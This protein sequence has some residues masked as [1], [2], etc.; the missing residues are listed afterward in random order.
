MKVSVKLG[1]PNYKVYL[2]GNLLADCIE[3]DDD[4]N[5]AI[6]YTT[7]IKGNYIVIQDYME[8]ETLYGNITLEE[9]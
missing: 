6:C 2:E 8:T 3:A 5:Y 7:D 9:I 1:K 4:E